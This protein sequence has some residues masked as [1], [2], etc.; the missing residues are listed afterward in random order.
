MTAEWDAYRRSLVRAWL[1]DV[2]R[3]AESLPG[4][5]SA[6]ADE[7]AAWDML[8]CVRYDRIGG[9]SPAV[10]GD[11]SMVAHIARLHASMS[12]NRS[13]L[14]EHEASVATAV[15]VFARLTCHPSAGDIM[16]M[17]WVDGRGWDEVAADAGYSV[18]H[19]KA[20]ETDAEAECYGL[21]PCE[22]RTR[23]PSAE[24]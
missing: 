7:G 5:R 23:V 18:A 6:V 17:R 9:P 2:R 20:I 3:D 11:D 22:R 4:L 16:R 15:G 8:G 14:A 10:E 24:E 1:K 21:M 12:R 13:L 19:A